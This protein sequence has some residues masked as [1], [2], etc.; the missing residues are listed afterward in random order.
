MESFNETV[1]P[2]RSLMLRASSEDELTTVPATSADYASFIAMMTLFGFS[3][4][5]KPALYILGAEFHGFGA[6]FKQL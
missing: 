3:A 4:L 2:V 6:W 1:Y 5:M